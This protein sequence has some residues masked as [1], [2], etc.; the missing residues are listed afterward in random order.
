MKLKNLL[1]VISVLNYRKLRYRNNIRKFDFYKQ[2]KNYCPLGLS[3]RKI[4]NGV[5][6]PEF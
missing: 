2:I 3:E 4:V 6:L 5:F 1:S